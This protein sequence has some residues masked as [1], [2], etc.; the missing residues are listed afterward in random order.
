LKPRLEKYIDKIIAGEQ[1]RTTE[2]LMRKENGDRLWVSLNGT[3]IKLGDETVLQFIARDI[4]QRKEAEERIRESE[5]KYRHLFESSPFVIG[6]VDLNG[7]VIDMN[8]ATNQLLTTRTKEDLIGKNIKDIFSVYEEE[9]PVIKLIQDQIKRMSN[10]EKGQPFEFPLLRADGTTQ[11][12]IFEGSSINIE[13]ESL[14]QFILKDITENKKAEQ[15]LKESEEKFRKI[16]EN[17]RVGYYEVDLKGNFTFFNET[18]RKWLKYSRDEL[19]GTNYRTYTSQDNFERTFKAFNEVFK[20]GKEINNFD[21]EIIAKDGS[22]IYGITTINLMYDSEGKKIGFSGFMRDVTEEKI[23][24]KKLKESEKKFRRIF[25][26]IPDLYFLV[27]EESVILDYKGSEEDL[28]VP[29]E[30]FLGKK[31]S[32]LLPHELGEKN[33]KAIKKTIETKEPTIIEYELP[34]KE[35]FRYYEARHLYFSK[36]QVAI[37]IRDLTERKKAELLIKEELIKLK[38]LDQIRK[39]LISRVSHELKTPLIPVISGAELLSTIYKNQ[40]GKDAKNIIEMIDKGGSRLK[41][42]IEKLINVSRIEY[43]KLILNKKRNDLSKIIK[44]ASNDMRYV[45]EERKLTLN[46]IVPEELY[47]EIDGIRIEEVVTNLLSNAIKNTPPHGKID[48]ELQ[49]EHDHVIMRVSDTGVGLTEKE[50]EVLF[51]RFGKIDRYQE[52]LEY[53]D[54]KGSGLGLYICKEIVEM[55]GGKIWAVSPGRNKG[56]SFFVRLPVK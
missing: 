53:I 44:D 54:I 25:E 43:D 42:L 18:L 21:Y 46:L 36:D 33:L 55:H 2:F 16:I 39:D 47:L 56:S 35:E 28:Y 3:L 27:S 49:D 11:W 31:M 14:V 32:E 1:T 10:G 23:A 24:E 51:T 15:I 30:T 50:M 13:G 8:S 48:I 9:R 45:L 38:E 17:A 20:T 12:V 26:S 22:I 29:P 4:T 52:G 37:F 6:L 7:N 19:A 34:I 41:T 40:I 5:L